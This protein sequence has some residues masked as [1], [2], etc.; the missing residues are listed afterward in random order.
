MVERQVLSGPERITYEGLFDVKELIQLYYDWSSDKGYVPV[1]TRH[2][3]AAKKEG[4]YIE[5]DYKPFKKVTDY[6]KNVFAI[7]MILSDVKDVVV[8]QDGT[9]KKLQQGKIQLVFQAWLETDYESRWEMKP[10]FYVLRTV[11][12][13]YIYTPFISGYQKE[14][15]EDLEL[16]KNNYKSYLNLYKYV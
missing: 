12:E 4:K 6:I 9:K 11:F 10:L 7:R 13:K 2:T 5:A 1:E 3:E 14:A 15:K 16:L 8:E